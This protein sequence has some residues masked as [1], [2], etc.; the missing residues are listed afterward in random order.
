MART[1]TRERIAFNKEKN[2]A[3]KSG[4]EWRKREKENR[5][6]LRA[7]NLLLYPDLLDRDPWIVWKEE[8]PNWVKSEEEKKRK[9]KERENI[10]PRLLMKSI[11]AIVEAEY[12][13]EELIRDY[14]GFLPEEEGRDN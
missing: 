14:I 7:G 1:I 3:Q 2:L 13:E 4:I 10:D 12:R 9:K 5:E 6:E 8:Y 11:V